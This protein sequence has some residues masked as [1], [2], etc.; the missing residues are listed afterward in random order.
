MYVKW[1]IKEMQQTRHSKMEV[2]LDEKQGEELH[3]IQ[4]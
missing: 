4:K 3:Q 1:T 2:T